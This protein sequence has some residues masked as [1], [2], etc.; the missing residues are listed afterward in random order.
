MV[1]AR[2]STPEPPLILVGL[3]MDEV[4]GIEGVAVKCLDTLKNTDCVGS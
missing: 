4:G 3:S 2:G 1:K